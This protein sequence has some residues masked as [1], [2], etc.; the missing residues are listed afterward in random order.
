MKF[1]LT[2]FLLVSLGGILNTS[3]AQQVKSKPPISTGTD[4]KLVYTT[5]SLGNRVPD[6]SWCGYKSGNIPVPDVPIRVI[7]PVK[8]GDATL[9]I[10]SAL[11][12]VATLPADA[13]G[14]RGA[15]LLEKGIYEVQ[16]SLLL[17]SSG[18]ALRGSGMT[19]AGTIL[20]GA[21]TDRETL[22]KVTGNKEHP[23]VQIGIENILLRSA[24]DVT[25]PKDEAHR[26]MAV[27]MEN[28]QDA[29][30]RQVVFEHFAGSAVCLL[31]STA[32]IT[33][34]DCKSLAPVSEIGGKRRYTFF[35]A[36]KQTL[37]QRIYAEYGY[38]D[39]AVGYGAEGP[40]AF[41]Q[42]ESHL[43]Y[44]YSGV[45]DGVADKVLLDMVNVDGNA[46]GFPS[47]GRRQGG[48][49]IRHS[50]LWQCSASRVDCFQSSGATNWGFGVWAEFAGNGA[51]FFRNEHI[52]PRSLYYAQLSDR[53]GKQ[54]L[55]RA[56]VLELAT[57]PATS[58]T[59]AK[60]AELT[61]IA[62]QPLL[63]LRDWIDQ[64]P[65]RQPVPV[66]ASGIKTID[67]IGY[68]QPSGNKMRQPMLLTGGL[69][70][71][72][73]GL[74]TGGTRRVSYWRGNIRPDGIRTATPHITRYVPGRTGTGLTD[75]LDAVTDWMQAKHIIGI[76]HNYGLW[77]DRRRDDHERIRRMD[78][79]VSA[80]FYE[81]P[82]ARSGQGT[83][84]DGLSKY[85]LT[86]YN[87]W[88]WKRLQDFAGLADQKGLVLIHQNY[89][90]H[91]I[92][93]AGGHYAD[94]PWR[95]ANNIN[96]TPFPEPPPYAGDKRI[97][98]AEQYYDI[99]NP[100]NAAYKALHRAYI[101]KCLDNFAGN[102]NVI[103]LIGA[104]YTGP[105]HFV[106]FWLD[107][108]K[109]WEQEKGKKQRVGLSVTKDVQDAILADPERSPVVDLI[110][111]RY[112]Y[113]QANGTV[114]APKGGMNMSP[115][116]HARQLNPKPSSFSQVYRAV[117]EYRQKYPAKAVTFSTDESEQFGWAVFMAGGSLAAIPPV[118][119]PAFLSDAASMQPQE[120]ADRADQ[121]QWVLANPG[122]AYI[123]YADS[124]ATNIKLDLS[125]VSGR[126]R[127]SWIDPKSGALIGKPQ[128]IR[129]GKTVTFAPPYMGSGVLY[130][131]RE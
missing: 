19:T 52:K 33:V 83:A 21:G 40:N 128:T 122:K 44:S 117:K 99:N 68:R 3:L 5:D 129:A 79:N 131:R 49:G 94:Y 71:T 67:A 43:P 130:I 108:I 76:D 98:L 115:R 42:C 63:V 59:F 93:E 91:N 105:L 78:G 70:T 24:Y 87:Q 9:R 39:F 23:V 51:W 127:A 35:T 58:P 31:E 95:T 10:Q 92:L 126:F 29:W 26:W 34:E 113:Y 90:Q 80:P 72:K 32:R 97:F 102:S 73:A 27:T 13:D 4:G 55:K 104:E 46:L 81:L 74:L 123:I 15:V 100:A 20:L 121:L 53:L 36:G 57:E 89:F 114:Y 11:D 22:I 85:D 112:W 50:V 6:F 103:Q 86:R 65:Q 14:I 8:P 56:Y 116:Q 54:V 41:V 1:L 84:W 106:Q 69:L 64:A 109:E 60:A 2:P 61:A 45:I 82:F 118:K 17:N 25:N 47:G 125:K 7:V 120:T 38:H 96:H 18:V 75:D 107:V 77:Y 16:G 111:I 28:A 119:E 110:D 101:R 62:R 48:G 124:A 37:F 30:V 66:A 12:Y 88:Y